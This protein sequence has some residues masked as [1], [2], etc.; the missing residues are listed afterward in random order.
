MSLETVANE[1]FCDLFAPNPVLLKFEDGV[2]PASKM[3]RRTHG[4]RAA[5][6]YKPGEV[7]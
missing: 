2:S 6:P 5:I 7:R 3:A 1:T 4:A